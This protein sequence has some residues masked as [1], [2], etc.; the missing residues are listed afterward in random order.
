[1]IRIQVVLGSTREN[2]FSERAALWVADGLEARG[3]MEVE[4]VD[5]RDHPLPFFDGLAPART[6]R[7]YPSAE[8]R[9]FGEPI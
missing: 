6:R 4:V 8:T 9:R 7:D 2:R 5:L 1:M 3:D